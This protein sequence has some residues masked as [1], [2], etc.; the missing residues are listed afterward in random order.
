MSLP[1]PV[2]IAERPVVEV[3]PPALVLPS[4]NL[5]TGPQST[6]F[7]FIKNTDFVEHYI[8]T[9]LI[10][11][12]L[13]LNDLNSRE[14]VRSQMGSPKK[15]HTMNKIRNFNQPGDPHLNLGNHGSSLSEVESGGGS[16]ITPSKT[17]GVRNFKRPNIDDPRK[18]NL[19]ANRENERI[20]SSP[21]AMFNATMSPGAG[22]LGRFKINL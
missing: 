6:L 5:T 17:F 19:T 2:L 15:L 1:K 3:Y 22:S 16:P 7:C 10:D 11:R 18:S 9:W 13:K 20:G 14:D 12:I 21:N 4:G 8:F